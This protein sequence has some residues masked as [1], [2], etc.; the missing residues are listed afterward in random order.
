MARLIVISILLI[1]TAVLCV[2]Y[3]RSK[4]RMLV[5]SFMPALV[6]TALAFGHSFT[7]GLDTALTDI[8]VMGLG[9]P[10]PLFPSCFAF[11]IMLLRYIYKEKKAA[12]RETET[13]TDAD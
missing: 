8:L 7:A 4:K 5:C 6:I 3:R 11:Q 1:V 10:F 2:V 13:K 12:V 9:G